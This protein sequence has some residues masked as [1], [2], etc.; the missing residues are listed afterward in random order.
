MITI[1]SVGLQGSIIAIKSALKKNFTAV[2]FQLHT[3]L[4][5]FDVKKKLDKFVSSVR[6]ILVTHC[7]LSSYAMLMK[8]KTE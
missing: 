2:F 4:H 1:K 8:L 3:T 5:F 6:Q 7:C